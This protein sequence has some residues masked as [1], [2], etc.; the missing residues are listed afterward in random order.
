MMASLRL[1]TDAIKDA[2]K[3]WPAAFKLC[4]GKRAVVHLRNP[5]S[6]N[7]A[8]AGQIQA[9]VAK[10]HVSCVSCFFSRTHGFSSLY[11]FCYYEARVQIQIRA[12]FG[13]KLYDFDVS[14]LKLQA[15]KVKDSFRTPNF[16]KFIQFLP[17]S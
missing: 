13:T 1:H 4:M 12:I 11:I 3:A 8:T 15:A 10:Y 14:K 9:L 6:M 16:F 7:F 2:I 17:D 5:A